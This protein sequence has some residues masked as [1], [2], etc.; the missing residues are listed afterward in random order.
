M[1]M[2]VTEKRKQSLM[3]VWPTRRKIEEIQE[4]GTAI[5]TRLGIS[6]VSPTDCIIFYLLFL[7][8]NIILGYPPS[9]LS[10]CR[11]RCPP[12]PGLEHC[13]Q[14]K[15]AAP[16]DGVGFFRF[17]GFQFRGASECSRPP[18]IPG[19]CLRLCLLGCHLPQ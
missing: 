10:P 11:R 13:R 6:T 5:T 7:S 12:R 14:P 9:L 16:P 15:Y 3:G 4:Y 19:L 2:K 17:Q 1:T 8:M 18:Q